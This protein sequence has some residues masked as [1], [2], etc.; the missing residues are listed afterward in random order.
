MVEGV[1]LAQQLAGQ[2]SGSMACRSNMYW[3]VVGWPWIQHAT[4]QWPSRLACMLATFCVHVTWLFGVISIPLTT[5]STQ[6]TSMAAY[7]APPSPS[8]KFPS[9]VLL[10]HGVVATHVHMQY[11]YCSYMYIILC[12]YEYIPGHFAEKLCGSVLY[13]G[14]SFIVVKIPLPDLVLLL[15]QSNILHLPS[16]PPPTCRHL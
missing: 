3:Y 4:C 8:H 15:H 10:V 11:P 14:R 12:G 5:L 1:R 7:Q 2:M 13:W 6:N 9:A 16:P